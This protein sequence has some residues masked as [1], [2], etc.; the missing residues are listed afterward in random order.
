MK[1]ILVSGIIGIVFLLSVG[2][3]SQVVYAGTGTANTPGWVDCKNQPLTVQVTSFAISGNTYVSV[4]YDAPKVD[5]DWTLVCYQN[6]F[7]QIQVQVYVIGI[8]ISSVIGTSPLVSSAIPLNGIV[9]P[10]FEFYCGCGAPL[11]LKAGMRI[12]VAISVTYGLLGYSHT[13]GYS[14]WV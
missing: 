8:G 3:L 7:H 11:T 2:I 13:G 5:W 9:V 12:T 4:V 6:S 1:K 10:V 14:F